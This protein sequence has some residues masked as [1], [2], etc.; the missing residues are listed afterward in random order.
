VPGASGDLTIGRLGLTLEEHKWMMS[1]GI[2]HQRLVNSASIVQ[3]S[4]LESLQLGGA[5]TLVLVACISSI[6]AKY[7]EFGQWQDS[8]A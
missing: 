1:L 3:V 2:C 7:S 5:A 8:Y 6:G 4:H